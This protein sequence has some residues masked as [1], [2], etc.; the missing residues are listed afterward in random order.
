MVQRYGTAKGAGKGVAREVFG[1]VNER[2]HRIARNGGQTARTARNSAGAPAH[3]EDR[4]FL[5]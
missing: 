3:N 5:Q 4:G 2:S 1:F